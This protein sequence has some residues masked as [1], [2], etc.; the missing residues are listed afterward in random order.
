V[1]RLGHLDTIKLWREISLDSASAFEERTSTEADEWGKW[2]VGVYD[3]LELCEGPMLGSN[4]Y[5]LRLRMVCTR[6]PFV[7]N[8]SEFPKVASTGHFGI[9]RLMFSFSA[10]SL[11]RG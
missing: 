2:T 8:V 3:D 4:V 1:K 7:R 9:D 11:L 10:Q 5:E 6:C